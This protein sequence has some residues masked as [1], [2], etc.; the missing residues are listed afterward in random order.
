MRF[1]IYCVVLFILSFVNNLG[2]EVAQEWL[3]SNNRG[4]YFFVPDD[5]QNQVGENVGRCNFISYVG[6][7]IT[8]SLFCVGNCMKNS[9]SCVGECIKKSC[10]GSIKFL[11]GKTLSLGFL[12]FWCYFFYDGLYDYE[13]NGMYN[14]AQRVHDRRKDIY[15]IINRNRSFVNDSYKGDDSGYIY[16]NCDDIYGKFEYELNKFT[17]FKKGINYFFDY[18]L[19]YKGKAIFKFYKDDCVVTVNKP[20]LCENSV[21]NCRSIFSVFNYIP[22]LKL[23]YNN[24]SDIRYMFSNLN[25]KYLDISNLMTENIEYI[26]GLF[27]NSKIIYF[28]GYEYKTFYN[29]IDFDCVFKN[30]TIDG[31]LDLANWNISIYSANEAFENARIMDIRLNNFNT[32]FLNF[33]LESFY[34]EHIKYLYLDNWDTTFTSYCGDVFHKNLRYVQFD[35]EKNLILFD[36]LNNDDD[37]DFWCLENYCFSLDGK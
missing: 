31:T 8:N 23:E 17:T 15:N 21:Y 24:F 4:E 29:I 6:D 19:D 13:K 32:R 34:S 36:Q 1:N 10:V 16:D 35:V 27:E 18:P 11:N 33:M 20:I 3:E 25:V 22:Y 5:Y 14:T 2:L 12:F 9:L 7:C 26:D 28:L 37:F 30:A